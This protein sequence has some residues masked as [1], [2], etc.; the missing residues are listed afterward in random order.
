MLNASQFPH[1]WIVTANHQ[2]A[3][4][5][6]IFEGSYDTWKNNYGTPPDWWKNSSYQGKLAHVVYSDGVHPTQN[7]VAAAVTLSRNNSIY[8][9]PPLYLF[10][11]DSSG[12][13][14]VACFF[15]QEVAALQNQ[16]PVAGKTYCSGTCVDLNSDPNHCGSCTNVCSSGTCCLGTCCN[17]RYDHANCGWCGHDCGSGQCVSGACY[18]DCSTCACGC[19]AAQT[20]CRVRSCS[21]GYF[22][23][24][25]CARVRYCGSASA[26]S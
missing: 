14:H 11:G 3:D 19:N 25:A 6:I 4:L 17:L 18:F 22:W 20:G 21:P 2:A 13:N 24:T 1:D 15:E 5:A 26:R 7:D 10:D 8:G 12:Y 9:S 23:M 16:P